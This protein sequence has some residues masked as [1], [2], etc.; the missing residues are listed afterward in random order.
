[1]SGVLVKWK[2]YKLECAVLVSSGSNDQLK[3]HDP[4]FVFINKAQLERLVVCNLCKIFNGG[5]TCN[6]LAG[7]SDKY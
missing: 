6:K 7:P 4:G 3:H 2:L 1:M 5:S